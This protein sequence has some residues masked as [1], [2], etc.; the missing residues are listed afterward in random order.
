MCY[1]YRRAPAPEDQFVQTRETTMPKVNPCQDCGAKC[2]GHIALEIDKPASEQDFDNIRWY[3]CHEG[4]QV[5]VE[6]KKWFLQ[7]ATRC[8]HLDE[9][10]LCRIYR[11]RPK[12]C[13]EYSHENCEGTSLDF[14][15]TLHL[16]SNADLEAYLAERKQRAAKRKARK[17]GSSAPA[18]SG[19][20]T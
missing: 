10:N 9:N 5:F 11:R 14:D 1:V 20:A 15:Y 8:R 13:R 16:K 12:I 18:R 3:L 2:C 17:A 6:D 19:G 4:V 7:V